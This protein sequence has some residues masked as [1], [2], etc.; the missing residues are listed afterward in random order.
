MA[1]HERR[2]LACFDFEG[3]HGRQI[4]PLQLNRTA[5]RDEVGTD[6]GHEPSTFLRAGHPRR[7]VPVIEAKLQ[8]EAH[9]NAASPSL[10]P[11]YYVGAVQIQRHCVDERDFA[12]GRRKQRLE[13]E[14]LATVGSPDL[15]RCLLRG[16]QPASVPGVAE[17]RGKAGWRVEPRKAKPV[18][19]AV[20]SDERGG[21]AVADQGVVF[22]R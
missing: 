17:K 7:R 4:P 6:D 21:A 14:R 3:G 18:D 13:D 8:L 10:H 15:P 5:N 1:Q 2:A 16:D 20:T 11:A 19:G 12:L 9:R 22:Y